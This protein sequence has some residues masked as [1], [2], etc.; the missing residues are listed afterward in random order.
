MTNILNV[1]EAIQLALEIHRNQQDKGGKPYIDHILRVAMKVAG[2]EGSDTELVI[3]AILHDLLEDGGA[4]LIER[5]VGRFGHEVALEVWTLTREEGE[6]YSSYIERVASHFR[7]KIV[8][9]A[10]LQDN[11]LLWRVRNIDDLHYKKYKEALERLER[12]W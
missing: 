11:L 7:A 1:L 3:T 5:V 12:G 10:D 9:V 4:Q 2:M 8:K 6:S